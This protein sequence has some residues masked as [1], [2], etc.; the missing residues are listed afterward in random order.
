MRKTKVTGIG[1]NCP[2]TPSQDQSTASSSG[3]TR[4]PREER[5]ERRLVVRENERSR[6]ANGL[7]SPAHV[8]RR[9]RPVPKVEGGTEQRSPSPVRVLR[10]ST[11]IDPEP[12]VLYLTGDNVN[13]ISRNSGSM[14]NTAGDEIVEMR[15]IVTR[16]EAECIG[17]D[18]MA[19]KDGSWVSGIVTT[20]SDSQK[21]AGERILTLRGNALLV[22]QVGSLIRSGSVVCWNYA[23]TIVNAAIRTACQ[24]PWETSQQG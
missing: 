24:G 17:I 16:V 1:G 5:V 22:S 20:I 19:L 15:C 11:P 6:R 3:T 14:T 9:Q 4:T 12:T 7:L 18:G 10:G 2:D 8:R 23:L 21:G 13:T